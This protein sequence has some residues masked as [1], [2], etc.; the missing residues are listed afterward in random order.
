MQG[1]SARLVPMVETCA[2]GASGKMFGYFQEKRIGSRRKTDM[3][4]AH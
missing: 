2:H 4:M 1:D 3:K